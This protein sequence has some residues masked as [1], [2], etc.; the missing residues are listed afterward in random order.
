MHCF[1]P[2]GSWWAV[3]MGPSCPG[4]GRHLGGRKALSRHLLRPSP[5]VPLMFARPGLALS[6]WE[7]PSLNISPLLLFGSSR[8]ALASPSPSPVS[9]PTRPPATALHSFA[10][11]WI[12]RLPS[13]FES[14][15]WPIFGVFGCPP[16][17]SLEPVLHLLHSWSMIVHHVSGRFGHSLSG[18]ML[19]R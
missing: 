10:S 4:V 13:C 9:P 12:R 5:A 17:R 19:P 8:L 15:L 6:G 11:C 1:M 7:Q 18:S 3:R 2:S 14:C 16:P